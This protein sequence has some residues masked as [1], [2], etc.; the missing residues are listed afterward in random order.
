MSKS[1]EVRI[2]NGGWN[3]TVYWR[4]RIWRDDATPPIQPQQTSAHSHTHHIIVERTSVLRDRSDSGGG[5]SG[6]SGSGSVSE[7]GVSESDRYEGVLSG[8]VSKR[9]W[10]DA[11]RVNVWTLPS[12]NYHTTASD[13]CY[14]LGISMEVRHSEIGSYVHQVPTGSFV[15]VSAV[16]PSRNDTLRFI[17]LAKAVV[18]AC[19]KLSL[20]RAPAHARLRWESRA[21]ELGF[22][23]K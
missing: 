2:E 17:T 1:L 10:K 8:E 14:H 22:G 18:G 11:R 6:V 15:M 4:C 13:D 7:S 19:E 9:L 3:H 5:V 23:G 21:R 16:S 20:L 12:T